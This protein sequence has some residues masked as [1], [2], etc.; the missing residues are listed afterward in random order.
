MKTL[1]VLLLS[2]LSAA[3]FAGAAPPTIHTVTA[4]PAGL[5][6]NGYLIEGPH[7]IVAIDTALTV[8]DSRALRA[9]FDGLHKPLLAVLLTHGHPDHYNGVATLVA[10]VPGEIPVYASAAVDAV[11]REWDER[12]D[13]QWKPVFKDEWPSVRQFPNRTAKNGEPLKIDGMTFVVH[14]LG[15][16]ESHADSYWTLEGPSRTAFVG[17]LVLNGSHA[18]TNDGHT[19]AWLKNLARVSKDL[20]SYKK[21]MPGHG[22]AGGLE[23]LTW[24]VKYLETYRAAIQRLREGRPSLTDAAKKSFEADMVAAYPQ[25]GNVFMI[26]LGADTVANEMNA[27]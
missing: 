5:S 18:Y 7:G 12:K 14:D 2:F 15:A 26:G 3:S 1:H 17:D 20:K 23:I 27:D 9:K 6:V 16:G 25:A 10:G 11:I 21:L 19:G 22:P 4:S 13:K 8:S 24:Q